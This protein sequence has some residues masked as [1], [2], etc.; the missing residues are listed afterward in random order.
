MKF[1]GKIQEPNNSFRILIF[2]FCS[3]NFSGTIFANVNQLMR[4]IVAVD[5]IILKHLSIQNFMIVQKMINSSV[6]F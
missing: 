4:T 3:A 5:V 1:G 6:D 2:H